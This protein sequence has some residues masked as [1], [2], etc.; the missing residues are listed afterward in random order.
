[1]DEVAAVAADFP[2]AFVRVVPVARHFAAEADQHPRDGV[3]DLA[4][5]AHGVGD[6]F[7]HFAVGVELHLAHR[8]VPD[9]YRPGAGVT[10][11]VRQRAFA[12]GLAAE[13]LVK[14]VQLR[15]R[16]VGRAEQPAH[17]VFGLV[18]VAEAVERAR[19]QGCVA[20]PAEA[21]VPIQV[22]TRPFG[23]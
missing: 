23:N 21:V 18:V 12:A 17:E 5:A 15:Q 14:D 10:G 20:Q 2:D 22:A 19:G 7:D 1:M 4:A 3:V 11:E 16:E 13:E 9:V 6:G 8:R